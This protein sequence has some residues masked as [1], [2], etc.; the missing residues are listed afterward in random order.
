MVYIVYEQLDHR[1]L[2]GR[3]RDLLAV[4]VEPES[5]CVVCKRTRFDYVAC[6][7][8]RALAA[9]PDEGLCLSNKSYR[10]ERLDN[11]IVG[12][13]FETVESVLVFLTAADYHD[14]CRKTFGSDALY[15]LKAVDPAHVYIKQDQVV[16]IGIQQI[17]SGLAADGQ[18]ILYA[19]ALESFVEHCQYRLIIIHYQNFVCHVSLLS[20]WLYS[21]TPYLV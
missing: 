8:R 18:V 13:D 16:L 11:I 21:Q 12:S 14:R 15:N 20:S 2:F 4:L 5:R 17:K 9:P 19:V 10:V 1:I 7:L 6:A 3:Q